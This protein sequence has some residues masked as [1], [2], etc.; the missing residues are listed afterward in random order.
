MIGGGWKLIEG[1][2]KMI[3]KMYR[4]SSV[5]IHHKEKGTIS[6]SIRHSVG[7]SVTHW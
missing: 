2:S 1:K 3:E 6:Q 5:P 7:H 4:K